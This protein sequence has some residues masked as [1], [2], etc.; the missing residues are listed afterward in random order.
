MVAAICASKPFEVGA[1]GRPHRLAGGF[2]VRRIYLHQRRRLIPD[3]GQRL[4]EVRI[5]LEHRGIGDHQVDDFAGH[6]RAVEHLLGGGLFKN[7]GDQWIPGDD[8]GDVGRLV[9]GNHIGV[10]GV[11]DL[12]VALAELDAVERAGE[13]IM[14]DGI[15]DK[16]DV[17]A[18]DIGK[19]R[20]VLEDDGVV[21]VRKVADDDGGRVDA[22][23][24]RKWKGHPCW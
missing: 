3:A 5:I 7:G 23:G 6:L 20:L 9:G 4:A 2:A 14:R 19:A 24:G 10:G 17:L 22:A 15:F 8:G 18:L 21:A 12:H 1:G 16:I 13:Q 11:D